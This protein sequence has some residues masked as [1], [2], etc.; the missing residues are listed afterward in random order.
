MIT[1]LSGATGVIY[2]R[3]VKPVLFRRL[4][5]NVHKRMLRI[6]SACQRSA[7][8]RAIMRTTWAYQN[9]PYLSQTLHGI[10]FANPIGLSAGFDKNFEL[11]PTMKAIGFGLMEG[12]S[13]TYRQCEGNPRPWFYR[14]PKSKSLVVHVGLANDGAATILERIQTYP[15]Q[16]FDGFPLNISVA[17]TNSKLT[18]TD[19]E[20]VK[21]YTG[22]LKLI[23]AKKV[24]DLVTLNISCPNTY[25]GEPFTTPKRLELLL[26]AVD[27]LRLIQPVFI[28]MP[29]NLAWPEFQGLLRVAAAHNVAGVIIGNLQKQRGGLKDVLPEE[30]Q[31]GLSGKPTYALSNELIAHTYRSFGDRFTIIGVGGVFSAD[32]AYTKIKL[33]AS[34]VELVTGLIFEGPELIGQINRGLVRRLQADGYHTI[35]EAVGAANRVP[36]RSAEWPAAPIQYPANIT[37]L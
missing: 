30:I 14:L 6:A 18:S 27:E 5:D 16:T 20:A 33:G 4:P 31:G 8:M 3:M 28:K 21:D 12:G 24:G 22:S 13:I 34:L 35:S 29:I 1:L 26:T 32:D 7:L 19:E 17:K 9:D 2:K 36:A 23:K 37:G 25:G 11:P 15:K 10:T